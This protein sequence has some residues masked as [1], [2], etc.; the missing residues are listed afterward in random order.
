MAIKPEE[1]HLNNSIFRQVAEL[2]VAKGFPWAD[3]CDVGAKTLHAG[4]VISKSKK[5]QKT[6]L[7]FLNLIN[8]IWYETFKWWNKYSNPVL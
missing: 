4:D 7:N 2:H 1:R 8:F 6:C 5:K 3:H